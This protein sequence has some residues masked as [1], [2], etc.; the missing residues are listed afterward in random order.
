MPLKSQSDRKPAA[1]SK[2]SGP[3]PTQKPKYQFLPDLRPEEREA[4]K[5]DIQKRGILI[6]V[7]KDEEGNILD[8]HNRDEIARELGIDCPSVTRH[9]KT[10]QEKR[11]HAIR[12][13]LVRR[14]LDPVRWGQAFALLLKERGVHTARGPKP[15]VAN[16]ATVAE[17]AAELGVPERTA[18]SRLKQAQQYESLP[19]PVRRAVDAGETTVKQATRIVKGEK[20]ETPEPTPTR[21]GGPVRYLPCPFCGATSLHLHVIIGPPSYVHCLRCL[22]EGPR[23]RASEGALDAWNRRA[24]Q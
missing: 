8:G 18:R 23:P 22:T 4:L 2:N 3:R 20:P 19:E 21:P 1:S 10:E 14:H 24:G 9:F 5:K 16:S 11:E 15:A 12:L 6:P 7:E 17:T 13:N